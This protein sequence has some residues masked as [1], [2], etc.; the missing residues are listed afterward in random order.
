M[1]RNNMDEQLI[2]SLREHRNQ[3]AKDLDDTR[4]LNIHLMFKIRELENEVK[5]L[6]DCDREIE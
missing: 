3:L 6:K 2:T 4:E 5:R 1:T